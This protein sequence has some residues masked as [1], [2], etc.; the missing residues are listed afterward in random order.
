MDSTE[1]YDLLNHGADTADGGQDLDG[2]LRSFAAECSRVLG[3]AG[4]AIVLVGEEKRLG[5][6]A[7]WGESV[8]RL[9]AVEIEAGQGPSVQC[10]ETG[11]AMRC[12]DT[13]E[14]DA[15]WSEWARTA[16][17]EGYY[18]AYSVPLLSM[19]ERL[20][21][22]TVYARGFGLPE[23]Q[24]ARLAPTLADAVAT[25]LYFQR[26]RDEHADQIAQLQRGI[27]SR[28]PI[29]QAKGILAARHGCT[30]D[31]AFELL[32]TV[33]RRRG[34]RLHDVARGIVDGVAGASEGVAAGN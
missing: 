24:A 11:V 33:S 18:S 21:A 6:A 22:M 25:G 12:A 31:E 9:A 14:T 5:C 3:V 7:A 19:D 16:L 13:T 4:V 28:V 27:A 20:G 17:R 2:H 23:T 15:R 29:E 30:I 10:A 8:E 32:R 34:M 1:V 26:R